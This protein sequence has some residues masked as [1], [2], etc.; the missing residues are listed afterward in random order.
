MP[1]PSFDGNS[2]SVF[3]KDSKIQAFQSLGVLNSS[4]LGSGANWF[5]CSARF[6]FF[7]FGSSID[8]SK[9]LGFLVVLAQ[10]LS[11]FIGLVMLLLLL[12]VS[13]SLSSFC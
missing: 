13:F 9:Q 3:L 10:A 8:S 6:F 4:N 12:S 5:L 1:P 2:F 11:P 7:C